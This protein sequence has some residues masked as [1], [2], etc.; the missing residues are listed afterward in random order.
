MFLDLADYARDGEIAQMMEGGDLQ[1][2]ETALQLGR[3]ILSRYPA[4]SGVVRWKLSSY[5]PLRGV[6]VASSP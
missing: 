1:F 5:S 6:A 2:D 4:P 3:M